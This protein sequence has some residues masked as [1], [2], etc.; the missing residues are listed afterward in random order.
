MKENGEEDPIKRIESV[1]MEPSKQGEVGWG[2]LVVGGR[3]VIS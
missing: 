2:V 1:E 3:V